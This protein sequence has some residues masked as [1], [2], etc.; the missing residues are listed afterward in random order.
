MNKCNKKI[1]APIKAPI[2]IFRQPRNQ[3]EA[4][5]LY[6]ENKDRMDA[7]NDKYKDET[8]DEFSARIM[9]EAS[10]EK[11]RKSDKAFAD[12]I[13]KQNKYWTT[14]KHTLPYNRALCEDSREPTI[15]TIKKP[16][17]KP[18][19]IYSKPNDG[20]PINEIKHNWQKEWFRQNEPINSVI[21]DKN[22]DYVWRRDRLKDYN[23]G[24][25]QFCKSNEY[26]DA[27]DNLYP[28]WRTK[29]QELRE[30]NKKEEDDRLNRLL[31]FK[32]KT[33]SCKPTENSG[34][35]YEIIKSNQQANTYYYHDKT[36]DNVRWLMPEDNIPIFESSKI[37]GNFYYTDNS[38][39]EQRWVLNKAE[40]TGGKR[41]SHK[42]KTANNGKGKR[43]YKKKGTRKKK[44]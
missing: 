24:F 15:K 26:I 38:T 40:N 25:R 14:E 2:S 3:A 36:N 44:M 33:P 39:G 11:K 42:K 29:Q 28:I 16:D 5:Q 35:D 12:A 27:N 41:K 9:G 32:P 37:L 10:V 8:A 18:V 30:A 19:A 31:S 1:K 17:L 7:Y 23:D 6:A 43:K 34:Y 4:D 22:R 13:K 20:N 21:L